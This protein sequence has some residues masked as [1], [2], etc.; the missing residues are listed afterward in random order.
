MGI[1]IAENLRYVLDSFISLIYCG[2]NCCAACG[3][4][5]DEFMQED[6]GSLPFYTLLCSK[7]RRTIDECSEIKHMQRGKVSVD[8]YSAVYYSFA[9]KELILKLKYKNNFNAGEVLGDLMIRTL[10]REKIEFDCVAFVPSGKNAMKKR[11][12]NQSRMLALIISRKFRKPLVNCICKAKDT[13]DQIGL[14]GYMRWYNLKDN[15]NVIHADKIK[16]KNILLV[17]DV[18]TTGATAFYCS[19]ALTQNGSGKVT[20]LTAARSTV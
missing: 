11:G 16:N 10:K 15:F 2:N 8:A 17:D 7:C 5:L 4:E 3:S 9:V 20:V 14:G 13:K 19:E 18:I 12:Y 6:E 1:R